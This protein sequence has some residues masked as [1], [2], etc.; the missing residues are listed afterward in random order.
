MFI[1]SSLSF[2]SSE[3]ELAEKEEKEGDLQ[4][5]LMQNKVVAASS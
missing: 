1:S 3:R 2:S 5:G 4:E